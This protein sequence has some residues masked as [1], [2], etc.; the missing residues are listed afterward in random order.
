VSKGYER[1]TFLPA[2]RP[3]EALHFST[4]VYSLELYMQLVASK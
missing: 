2:N 1:C 4:G 3:A